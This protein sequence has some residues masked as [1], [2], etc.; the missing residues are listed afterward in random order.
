MLPTLEGLT[1]SPAPAGDSG[2]HLKPKQHRPPKQHTAPAP[3]RAFVD[4]ADDADDDNDMFATRPRKRPRAH[5]TELPQPFYSSRQFNAAPPKR[6]QP[7][8]REG[9]SSQPTE[10]SRHPSAAGAQQRASTQPLRVKPIQARSPSPERHAILPPLT[11]APHAPGNSPRAPTSPVHTSTSAEDVALRLRKDRQAAY[12]K[13]A[14]AAQSSVKMDN[15][16]PQLRTRGDPPGLFHLMA[17]GLLDF[18]FECGEFHA[19]EE[20]VTNWKNGTGFT[21]RLLAAYGRFHLHFHQVL[22]C[23]LTTCTETTFH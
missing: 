5:V 20:E 10:R 4:L 7:A 17:C 13:A 19:F 2:P 11:P 6:S 23:A 3:E 15:P 1:A 9:Q 16:K 22:P 14:S 18:D 21:E 8:R 12:V